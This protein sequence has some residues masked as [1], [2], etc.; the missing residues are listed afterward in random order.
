MR[1]GNL[2]VAQVIFSGNGTSNATTYT[3]TLPVAARSAI[4]AI[5][6]GT[7]T[8]NG[9]NLTTP[10]RMDSRAASATADLYKDFSAAAWTCSGAKA[11][12]GTIVYEAN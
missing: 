7:A 9:V 2:I 8:D 6:S 3:M 5:M 12:V 4:T 11:C 1:V 10:C